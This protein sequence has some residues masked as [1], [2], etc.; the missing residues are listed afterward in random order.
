MFTA[1]NP[2]LHANPP[3]VSRFL[4]SGKGRA[5]PRR[6]VR[7]ERETACFSVRGKLCWHLLARGYTPPP[8]KRGFH[9][10]RCAMKRRNIHLDQP[11]FRG[12]K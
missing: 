3:G 4:L 7:R 11:W 6:P 2:A 12:L 9:T 10:W 5:G 1:P 8:L